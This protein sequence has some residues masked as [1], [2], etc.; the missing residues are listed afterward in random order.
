M[1]GFERDGARQ[2]AFRDEW[3]RQLSELLSVLEKASEEDDSGELETSGFPT[4]PPMSGAVSGPSLALYLYEA[5]Q[6]Y[7]RSDRDS[8]VVVIA[9][10]R[11]LLEDAAE[12]ACG[13]GVVMGFKRSHD[14]QR[15]FEAACER[16]NYSCAA[17]GCEMRGVGIRHLTADHIIP[18]AKDGTDD[19][20]NI[21]ALC[22]SCNAIKNI[23]DM[24]YLENYLAKLAAA[25]P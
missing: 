16:Q 24:E 12:L 17:G 19:M 13:G 22:Y 11:V 5:A 7:G 3:I 23:R 10:V 2:Q 20:E 6:K 9:I 4:L 1:N 21:Q 8:L 18:I 25:P 15:A 14:V